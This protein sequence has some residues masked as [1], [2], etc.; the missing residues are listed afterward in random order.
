[1]YRSVSDIYG[2]GTFE[3]ADEF[4]CMVREAFGAD[5]VPELIVEPD[6][7]LSVWQAPDWWEDSVDE[8]RRQGEG[9]AHTVLVPVGDED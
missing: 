8:A 6:G 3:N 9:H 4:L 5:E 7:T 1:M 2:D